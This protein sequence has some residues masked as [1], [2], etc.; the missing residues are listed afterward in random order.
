MQ[1]EA[2]F[3]IQNEQGEWHCE[4]D[5]NTYNGLICPEGHYKVSKEYFANQCAE[6]GLHCSEGHICYCRPC[7]RA[8]EVDVFPGL[9][10]GEI[11]E[12]EQ[13]CS[14]MSLCGTVEQGHEITFHTRDNL[15]RSNITIEAV[16]RHGHELRSLAVDYGEA[17]FFEYDFTFSHSSKGVQILEVFVDGEQIPESPFRIEVIEKECQHRFMIAS[18]A[19]V[20][21]CST[22]GIHLLG[23]C[24]SRNLLIG[25]LTAICACILLL[26]AIFYQRHRRRKQDEMWQVN[27]EELNFSHPVEVIGQGGFGLVLLAEYRGT[28]VAI[29]R[30]LPLLDKANRGK[31]SGSA[32]SLSGKDHQ[33]KPDEETTDEIA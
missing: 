7:I 26:I 13:S 16:V 3:I 32:V 24:I 29:K 10:R 33:E 25:V 2:G 14:K 19:G 6:T 1:E 12:F 22:E 20:C 5:A 21:E 17:E 8:H 11:R 30:V 9:G 18:D 15:A 23:E 31:R 27:T 28:K 4:R